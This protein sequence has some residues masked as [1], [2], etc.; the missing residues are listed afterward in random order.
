MKVRD[1]MT[2]GVASVK[3]DETLSDAARLMWDCDCGSVPVMDGSVV[4]G[5]LTDRDI[6]M[7]AWS[8]N[9]PPNAIRVAEA[10]SRELYHCA[11]DDSISF[12]EDLM[13]ARQVRR[14]PVLD[15]E[16]RL[17]GILSLA[18]IV[19]QSR[20]PALRGNGNGRVELSPNDV[21]VTLATICEPRPAASQSAVY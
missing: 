11:A 16:Q 7:A 14:L 17:V 12:A 3:G 1:L 8:K 19:R 9:Q 2:T 18:D 15:A 20:P 21:A 4:V 6:C 10:M 13:Q 5:M